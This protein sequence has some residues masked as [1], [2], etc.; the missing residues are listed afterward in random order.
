MSETL[1]APDPAAATA[2]PPTEAP[3]TTTPAATAAPAATPAPTGTSALDTAGTED[4]KVQPQATW[5]EDWRTKLG[6]DDEKA[7]KRLARFGS[8]DAVWKSYTELEKKLSS[9]A[10]KPAAPAADA[11]A[12]EIAAYR[13]EL[14]V[15]EAPTGYLSELP[16]GIQISDADKPA[17]DLLAAK[18]HGVNAPPAAVHAA[19][20]TLYAARQI[21]QDQQAQ[22]DTNAKNTFEETMRGEWGPQYTPHMNAIKNWATATLGEAAPLLL[23]ARL[24][25]GTPLGSSQPV[26]KALLANALELNPAATV[27][28]SG[29]GNAIASIEGRMKEIEATMGT[30]AYTKDAKVRAEYRTL[31]EAKQKMTA[32]GKAA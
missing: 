8:P 9:G 22:N 14:G 10:L 2:T 20:E 16:K 19:I 23:G 31:I 29:G 27:V 1:T 18:M 17:M 24:A 12:E 30:A 25:D 6:G 13:K 26:L 28:P 4:V 7:A 21:V 11:P 15:P 3:A 32:R 5:P